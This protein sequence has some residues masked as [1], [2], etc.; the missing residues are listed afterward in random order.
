MKTYGLPDEERVDTISEIEMTSIQ[1]QEGEESPMPALP[2]DEDQS[3]TC[4][5]NSP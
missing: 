1:E 5:L 3:P 2:S 4:K